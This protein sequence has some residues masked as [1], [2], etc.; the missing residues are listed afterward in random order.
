MNISIRL[1]IMLL[2]VA[3]AAQL[4][5]AVTSFNLGREKRYLQTAQLS[6][7]VDPEGFYYAFAGTEEDGKESPFTAVSLVKPDE[8]T[9]NLSFEEYDGWWTS[10]T[11]P[12]LDEL[13]LAFPAGA[14]SLVGTKRSG[15]TTEV[16]WTLDTVEFPP[17]P[18]ITNYDDL[19]NVDS[20]ADTTVSWSAWTN[21]TTSDNIVLVLTN[22][23]DELLDTG[24]TYNGTA[25]SVTIPE[26]TMRPGRTYS[27][28][29]KFAQMA[30][31]TNSG[32]TPDFPNAEKYVFNQ[33]Q[34]KLAVST[35][36]AI[37]NFMAER[38]ANY[39]QTDAA[40]IIPSTEEPYQGCI[41]IYESG[42]ESLIS[43]GTVTWPNLSTTA[44]EVETDG[45]EGNL[46]WWA[47][48]E[49]STLS[50]LNAQF[51]LGDYTLT[52]TKAAGGTFDV[53]F[54]MET[55]D[56]PQTPLVTNYDALQTIDC[57]ADTTITWQ[58]WTAGT[59]TDFIIITIEDDEGDLVY[60]NQFDILDGKESAYGT[61]TST[62]IPAG[63]FE[64]CSYYNLTVQ[65]VDTYGYQLTGGVPDFPT[66]MKASSAETQTTL[67]IHTSGRRSAFGPTDSVGG[68]WD[69]NWGWI[70]DTDYP[71]VYS[72]HHNAWLYLYDS[73]TLEIANGYWVCY[74]LP[75]GS[76]FGWGYVFANGGWWCMAS[77]LQ[78]RWLTPQDDLP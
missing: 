23:D 13:N 9:A 42:P 45:D 34:T 20:R 21:G 70:D 41:G 5:A 4:S 27:L 56:F 71:W 44:L 33:T 66:A 65:F 58:P 12:S 52:L 37:Y 54:T 48:D 3:T 50:A 31:Q 28:T 55:L 61:A 49:Y 6:I 75:D 74:L 40:T 10:L 32:G 25:T 77:D 2:T 60:S 47:Y 36:S 51:P 8:S 76:D 29:V 57:T 73:D 38:R 39:K 59:S 15:G 46:G 11:T 16:V 69:N 63:T 18:Y 19:Q 64:K 68:K 14:Y 24:T 26:D 53:D 78:W 17:L 30:E 1:G 35:E 43:A 72:Y 22:G 62:V 67:R 7:G